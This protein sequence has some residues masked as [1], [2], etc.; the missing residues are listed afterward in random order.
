[1]HR[2]QEQDCPLTMR[3]ALDEYFSSFE[4]RIDPDTLGEAG[5]TFRQHDACHV[6]FGTDTSPVGETM[7]DM[8]SLF[9]TTLTLRDAL[10]YYTQ[11]ELSE[12][13]KSIGYWKF[14][15][16]AIFGIPYAIRV[17]WRSR[18]M[19]RRWSWVGWREHLD[20]PLAEIR[21]EHGI[22]VLPYH[23]GGDAA[24]MPMPQG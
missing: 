15:L 20:R 23:A 24:P 1:M 18:R 3:E 7:T 6:V 19:L 14:F 17:V 22:R 13:L 8:W 10:R 4:E 2:Y 16:A 5:E 12:A 11:P 9:G 21:R